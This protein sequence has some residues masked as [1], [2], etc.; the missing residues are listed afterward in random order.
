MRWARM[1]SR[2]PLE[3]GG[4]PPDSPSADHGLSLPHSGRSCAADVRAHG[5]AR[6]RHGQ[7]DERDSR[8]EECKAKQ[9]PSHR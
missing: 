2:R 1:E 4:R 3:L 7:D 6:E 5:V 8:A 9:L